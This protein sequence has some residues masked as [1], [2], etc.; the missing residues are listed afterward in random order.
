MNPENATSPA[1]LAAQ[2]MPG[3][4]VPARLWRSTMKVLRVALTAT[5]I[6]T[7]VLLALMVWTEPAYSPASGAGYWMGVTGGSLMLVLLIYPLRKRIAVLWILGPIRHWFRLHLFAGSPG[8]SSCCST[9]RFASVHSMPQSR[10]RRC[11]W[12][13]PAD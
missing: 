4:D 10:S 5:L 12:W 8:R 13:W 11:C 7:V 6:M 3:M 1:N 2:V 9:P